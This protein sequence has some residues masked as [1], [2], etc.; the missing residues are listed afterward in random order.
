MH[1]L[2]LLK[3]HS[4][5]LEHCRECFRLLLL[6]LQHLLQSQVVLLLPLL[7]LLFFLLTFQ[8]PALGAHT[9][10]Q[11]CELLRLPPRQTLC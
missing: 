2:L 9:L 4:Q 5:L 8:P 10:L 6:L 1:P 11:L 3:L 7:L